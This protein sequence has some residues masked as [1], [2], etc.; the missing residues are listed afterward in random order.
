M[1]R[2]ER[3][4]KVHSG[5][6]KRH[7][8]LKRRKTPG[9][10]DFVQRLAG[11]DVVVRRNRAATIT[12]SKL[13]A[14]LPEFERAYNEG[15]IEVKTPTGQLVDLKTLAV[16]EKLPAP[17]PQPHPPLDSAA[18]DTQGVGEKMPVYQDGKALDETAEPP[19][20]PVLP[21]DDAEKDAVESGHGDPAAVRK[22]AR[23]A[24]KDR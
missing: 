23:K 14:H 20:K 7:T 17:P 16:V 1:V 2:T 11:G 5:V 8:K 18:R 9:R 22:R 13:K 4:F 3:I 6:R 12:E 10:P 21:G 19:P 24:K 15:R